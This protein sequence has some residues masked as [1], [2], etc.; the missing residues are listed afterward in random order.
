M[1][2][3]ARNKR[4]ASLLRQMREEYKPVKTRAHDMDEVMKPYR[5]KSLF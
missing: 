3:E 4:L 2:E 1:E 5:F